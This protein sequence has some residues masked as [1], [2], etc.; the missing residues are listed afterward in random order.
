MVLWLALG[1]PGRKYQET[2]H[3]AGLIMLSSL[4]K[5]PW[6]EAPKLKSMVAEI[7]GHFFMFPMTYMN[8]SGQALSAALK[9]YNSKV[10]SIVVLHDEIELSWPEV[11]LKTG[12]GHKGHNGLRDIMAHLGNGDFHRVRI[13]VGRP[14]QGSVSDYVLSTWPV[15][16]RPSNEKCLEVLAKLPFSHPF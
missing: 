8:H 16:E 5:L 3:N 1:N 15:S 12:G 9:K 4:I 10:E 11:R 13:G 6:Q 14:I 7:P 2:R